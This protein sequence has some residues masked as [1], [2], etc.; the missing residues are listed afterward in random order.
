MFKNLT[1]NK[2]SAIVAFLVGSL[3]LGI[4]LFLNS[5]GQVSSHLV[6]MLLFILAAVIASFFLVKYLLGKFVFKNIQLIYKMIRSTRQLDGKASIE[7]L[8]QSGIN[9]K[10]LDDE[11]LQWAERTKNEITDLKELESY[12]R[13]YIGNVSHELKTPIFSIQ[14]YLHTLIEGG[15]YDEKINMR[16]LKKAA[17]N[18]Q[19]LEN[20]VKD[21]EIVN[22]LESDAALDLKRFDIQALTLEVFQELDIYSSNRNIKFSIVEAVPDTFLVLADRIKIRQVLINLLTN[23]VRYSD[24]GGEVSVSFFDI[25]DSILIEVSDNGIGI[26]EQHL[27]HLFDRFYRVDPSRSRKFGGSGL[28]LSIVKHIIEAHNQTVNVRSTKGV[29]STFAFTLDKA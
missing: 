17:D 25:Q 15:I 12:R 20:I 10:E 24:E 29:G 16:Y 18:T 21:L 26:E 27:K 11:V 23:S 13:N 14:G 5:S 4:S 1:I 28:G 9:L 8:R 6:Q 3:H 19:R 2:I 7:K 22:K